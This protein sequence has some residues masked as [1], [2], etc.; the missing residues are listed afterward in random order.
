MNNAQSV[1]ETEEPPDDRP[2][3][4]LVPVAEST[5]LRNAVAYAVRDARERAEERGRPARVHFVYAQATRTVGEE[6]SEGEEL[7]E[8]VTVWAREDADVD[9]DDVPEWLTIETAVVGAEEYLFH[10]RDYA[11]VIDAYAREHDLERLV[12]DP[13]YA[14]GGRAP[15]LRP[16]EAELRDAGLTVEEAP[17][18]RPAR[19]PRLV[20]AGGLGQFLAVFGA[21]YLFYLVIGGFA[22]TF[23]LATGAISAGIVAGILSRISFARPP[24]WRRWPGI[25]LRGAI[26]VPYFLWEIAKANVEIAKVILDPR[27]PIDPKMVHFEAM[28]WDELSVTGLANSITLT[29]GTLTVDVSEHD[30]HVHSMTVSAR[31]DLLDGGLERAVRFVFYGRS[32]ARIPSPR[33]RG[34]SPDAAEI[35]AEATDDGEVIG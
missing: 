14:P 23:D 6:P 10:P 16:V 12:V 4:V 9:E 24:T 15:L 22:G 31:Q 30:F 21:S 2:L 17:V 20:R 5:T 33:D 8:R 1:V 28:V 27:L 29:P 35:D 11:R 3:D 26:Y 34:A 18:E 7:L 19:R 13:A 25:L 32:A